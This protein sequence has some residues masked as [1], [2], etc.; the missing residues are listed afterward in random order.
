M[1]IW[2]MAG[3]A[4]ISFCLFSL[5][6][7]E[8]NKYKE[9]HRE[10]L[11]LDE[12]L[13]DLAAGEKGGYI[14]V[15]SAHPGI[16]NMTADLNRMLDVF[17]RQQMEYQR[18]RRSM[19][20]VL[21]NISHDLRTPLTVLKGYSEM[22]EREMAEH[23]SGKHVSKG[24]TEDKPAVRSSS[25][26]ERLR[27]MTGK[28]SE[29]ADELAVLMQ[30]FFTLSKLESGDMVLH[31]QRI[32]LSRIC[33]EVLLDYYNLLEK[34]HFEADIRMTEEP[35]PVL[36]DAGAVERILKNLL[37]NAI[38]YGEE[39]QYLAFRLC[40][41]DGKVYVEVEDHGEGIAP[42]EQEKIFAR[43]YTKGRGSGLGLA[44]AGNLAA[45][46]RADLTVRSEKGEG[47][48]FRLTFAS[49]GEGKSV[50]AQ[51]TEKQ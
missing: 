46:M 28:I 4:F 48:V 9:L 34:K 13:R 45:Q 20:Q 14:L 22:L 43:A 40:R 2:M 18:T 50:P 12:R 21:T 19:E 36:T 47:T 1:N 37:D 49:G 30:D 15:P 7:W 5:Y 29:K 41:Q 51:E 27:E 23:I 16:R 26:E 31:L 6:V 11:Y 33:H 24:D 44:I 3:W 32:N 25:S 38:K 39:G 35:C 8:R 10:I 17:Y 42:E